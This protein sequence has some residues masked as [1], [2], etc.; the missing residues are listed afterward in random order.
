MRNQDLDFQDY[1]ARYQVLVIKTL[2][3][4]IETGLGRGHGDVKWP[5]E[6]KGGEG[7]GGLM[8]RRVAVEVEEMVFGERERGDAKNWGCG[9]LVDGAQEVGI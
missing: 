2:I 1:V 7:E 6:E 9:M 3:G 5:V 4:M 8:K